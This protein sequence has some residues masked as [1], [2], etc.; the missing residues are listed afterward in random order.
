MGIVTEEV[1][2]KKQTGDKKQDSNEKEEKEISSFEKKFINNS[3]NL[4]KL[5]GDKVKIIDVKN[6]LIC[7]LDMQNYN[8][9]QMFKSNHEQELKDLFPQDKFKKEDIPELII[10]KQN[11][12]LLSKIDKTNKMNNKYFSVTTENKIVFPLE[13]VQNIKKEFNIISFNYRNRNA[14]N[15]KEKIKIMMWMKEQYPFKPIIN[16]KS[17]KLYKKYKDKVLSIQNET[18]TSNT[19]SQLKRSNMEYI[20]RI[21]LLDKKKIAETQKI[22]EEMEKKQRQECTFKPR[23]N[24]YQISKKEKK[25]K[26]EN[27]TSNDK[28]ELNDKDTNN[29]K[30]KNENKKNKSKFEELYEKGKNKLKNKIYKTREEI[31]LEEQKNECTFQPNIKGLDPKKIPK[32]NFNNDIY[33]EKEYQI[34]YERLKHGRLERMV[35]D[36]NND[37]YGLNNELKQFVKDNKEYNFIQNQQYFDPNDPFYYNNAEL[38]N[39]INNLNNQFEQENIEKSNIIKENDINK[40]QEKKKKENNKFENKDN[41]SNNDEM[42]NDNKVEYIN[43]KLNLEKNNKKEEENKHENEDDKDK[44]DDIPLLIIDVNIRQ[45]VKKKIY[46]YEGDTPKA[47][48]EK[49]AKEQNLDEETKNKLQGLIHTHMQK[50]LTRIEEENQSYSEKSQNVHSQKNN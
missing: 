12:E 43:N 11:E 33:N 5:G 13:K 37:R 7:I 18:V 36:S 10:A 27:K 47:L 31:E 28:N 42:N 29:E 45:G 38:N 20:D 15:N 17:N 41:N 1:E 48:A 44:N 8:L 50:L 4:L 49:F 14:K 39:M 22:K 35:K 9:Y 21:L 25:Q 2:N 6:F 16:E 26:E 32:T 24:S 23:I 40:S 46:V 3:V 19:N 30:I 34:L